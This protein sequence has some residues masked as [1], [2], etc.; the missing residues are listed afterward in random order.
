[1][2]PRL[3]GQSLLRPSVDQASDG[4]QDPD[5]HLRCRYCL[6]GLGSSPNVLGTTLI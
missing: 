1:M 3:S 5:G 6:A 4:W 2:L